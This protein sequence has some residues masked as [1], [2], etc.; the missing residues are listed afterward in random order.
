MLAVGNVNVGPTPQIR[1]PGFAGDRK[2]LGLMSPSPLAFSSPGPTEGRLMIGVMTR[3]M[4]FQSSVIL[5]GI[6]GW[7]FSTYAVFSLEPR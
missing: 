3:V 7:T 4:R 1:W 5:I 2:K 6:T